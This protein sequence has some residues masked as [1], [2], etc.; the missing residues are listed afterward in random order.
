LSADWISF[1]RAQKFSHPDRLKPR[2]VTELVSPFDEAVRP[3][4]IPKVR[5][6]Y[7]L[8]TRVPL[9]LVYRLLPQTRR[10]RAAAPAHFGS[11]TA[12]VT[13]HLHIL[14]A[15]YFISK[16]KYLVYA[17]AIK[18]S[19]NAKCPGFRPGHWRIQAL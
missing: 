5:E 17:P 19:P 6:P 18:P 16:N 4:I 3:Q 13:Q 10:I 8:H 1:P 2:V 7:P 15:T 14:K 12:A 11:P 9:T